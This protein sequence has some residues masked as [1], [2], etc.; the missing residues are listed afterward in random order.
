MVRSKT[1]VLLIGEKCGYCRK[2]K[3]K[4]QASQKSPISMKSYR[5]IAQV[6]SLKTTT[7]SSAPIVTSLCSRG[8]G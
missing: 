3:Q 6:E 1:M 8:G 7:A 5:C 2:K 4:I